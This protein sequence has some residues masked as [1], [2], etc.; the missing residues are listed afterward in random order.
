MGLEEEKAP[1]FMQKPKLRQDEDEDIIFFECV[2]A[3]Y[4]KPEVVWY[5]ND[6]V[7]VQSQRLI[8]QIKD[9]SASRFYIGLKIIDP[10]DDDSGL[11]KISVTNVK[12]N[13]IGSIF[14]NF[15]GENDSNFHFTFLAPFFMFSIE[16]IMAF[17]SLNFSS[18]RTL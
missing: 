1:T 14:A 3:A 7:I 9:L 5:F 6:K 15:K 4:P 13:A 17:I 8:P 16:K 11:Y 2:V 18:S 12:G 10:E